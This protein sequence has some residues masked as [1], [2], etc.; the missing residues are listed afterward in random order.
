MKGD[1]LLN[2]FMIGRRIRTER[3]RMNLTQEK[4]AEDVELTAA[5]IGQVERGERN[6]TLENIIKV[7]NRLGVTVDYLLSDSIDADKDTSLIQLSQLLNGR[8]LKEKELAISLIKTLFTHL[9]RD[10]G[11]TGVK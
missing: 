9:D 2:E 6:L 10:D 5:Y 1:C 7:A 4:L 11:A 8:S 3:L